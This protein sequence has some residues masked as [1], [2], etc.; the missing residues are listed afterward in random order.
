ML[1]GLNV[2]QFLDTSKVTDLTEKLEAR[3]SAI[4]KK[5]DELAS[6]QGE[7]DVIKKQISTN[8]KMLKVSTFVAESSDVTLEEYLDIMI[9]YYNIP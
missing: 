5:N 3:D 1:L 2:Y 9:D 4:K 6:L 7:L 8:E